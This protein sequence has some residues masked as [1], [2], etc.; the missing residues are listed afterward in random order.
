MEIGILGNREILHRE[1]GVISLPQHR[2]KQLPRVSERRCSKTQEILLRAETASRVQ[3]DT[4]GRNS[5]SDAI[6]NLDG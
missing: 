1:I 4:S 2:E 3:V 6:Q 5:S